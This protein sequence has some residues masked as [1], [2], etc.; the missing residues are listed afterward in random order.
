MDTPDTPEAPYKS[1]MYDIPGITSWTRLR[2]DPLGDDYRPTLEGRVYDP[3]W[4]LARQW[5]VGEFAGEDAG[6]PINVSVTAKGTTL[7]EFTSGN[8]A[9]PLQDYPV[10]FLAGCEPPQK[11]NIIESAEAGAE[12]VTLMREYGCG[13]DEIDKLTLEYPLVSAGTEPAGDGAAALFAILSPGSGVGIGLPDP[14]A[15]TGSGYTLAQLIEN[16]A[17][18]GA[19]DLRLGIDLHEPAA[20]TEASRKWTTWLKAIHPESPADFSWRD[21]Y[22]EHSFALEARDSKSNSVSMIAKSW[23]GATLDWYSLDVSDVTPG[24][25]SSAP[26]RLRGMSKDLSVSYS[27]LPVALTY[28]G[29]PA[30][31]WWEYEDS[32]VNY[33]Q[34]SADENDLA[35]LLVV[36][37]AIAN[38]NDWY[39]IPMELPVGAL[40]TL[41]EFTVKNTFNEEITVPAVSGGAKRDWCVFRMSYNDDRGKTPHEGLLLYPTSYT[42]E[43]ALVER[44]QFFRDETANI[45]WAAETIIEGADGCPFDRDMNYIRK[46]RS[47]GETEDEVK[48]EYEY[49]LVSIVPEHWFPLTPTKGRMYQMQLMDLKVKPLG[50]ILKERAPGVASTAGQNSWFAFWQNEIP[51]EGSEVLRRYIMTRDGEGKVLLWRGRQKRAGY[52]EGA[53]NLQYDSLK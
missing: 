38:G 27:G 1:E 33:L 7:S 12:L 5:Q 47:A 3:A 44:V 42:Q 23:D 25:S 8:C 34:I 45:A 10:S 48:E 4:M 17:S 16:T 20:F 24:E 30:A 18:G 15:V 2:P 37:F 52:G 11:Y 40:Y 41:T 51:R 35:R 26:K 46:V 36:E 9:I 28:A 21:E 6:S 19:P 31:R 49:E 29:M 13:E 14:F 39:I 53:S 43:S 32:E 22:L 50:T